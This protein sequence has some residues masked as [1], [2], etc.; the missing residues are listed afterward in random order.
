MNVKMSSITHLRKQE[1]LDRSTRAIPPRSRDP[2]FVGDGTGL[3]LQIQSHE[4][5]PLWCR[6]Q[7]TVNNVLLT[8]VA[9]HVQ[10]DTMP[11]AIRPG[12]TLR[13]ALLNSSELLGEKPV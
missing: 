1:N 12:F 2:I 4:L 10:A 8:N 3:Q 13:E 9:A 7:W 5:K 11:D 6:S